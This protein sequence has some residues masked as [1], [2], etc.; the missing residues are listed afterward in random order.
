MNSAFFPLVYNVSN[1]SLYIHIHIYN[2]LLLTV[3]LM[4]GFR[5]INELGNCKSGDSFLDFGTS[6]EF[7]WFRNRDWM[8]GWVDS[9]CMIDNTREWRH[10]FRKSCRCRKCHYRHSQQIFPKRET[11]VLADFKG[12]KL[13]AHYIFYIYN[14]HFW[15][16]EDSL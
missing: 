11:L 10:Y 5:Y 2:K 3:E 7:L 16:L 1:Q 15:R 13:C 6:S 12:K 8:L 14:R 9:H 4:S